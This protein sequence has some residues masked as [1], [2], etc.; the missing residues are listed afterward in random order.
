MPLRL[1]FEI[2]SPMKQSL[3]LWVAVSCLIIFEFGLFGGKE[4]FRMSMKVA[5]WCLLGLCG[6]CLWFVPCCSRQDHRFSESSGAPWGLYLC[7]SGRLRAGSGDLF[8]WSCW[9][10]S[11]CC[12]CRSRKC[13]SPFWFFWLSLACC[14][15]TCFRCWKFLCWV[16]PRWTVRLGL[17]LMGKSVS[18][19]SASEASCTWATS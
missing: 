1:G 11:G 8:F 12:S 19:Y 2:R 3:D 13:G 5:L 6:S 14:S 10:A 18:L 9:A 4:S 15:W 16:G 7:S 17:W